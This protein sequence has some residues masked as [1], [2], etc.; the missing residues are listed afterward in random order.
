MSLHLDFLDRLIAFPT[1]S[2]R[3]N[4][5]LIAWAQEILSS[6][7][8]RVELFPDETG[9]K[10]SLLATIG[11][12]AA[13]GLLL[14]GHSD[15]VPVEGQA[16]TT[17]PFEASERDGRVYGR[18][19]ADMKGFLA[20][21][22]EAMVKAAARPPARPL[23]LAIS[24][25]EEIGCVGVR[26]MLRALAGRS[27]R[28]D[29]VLV[30]EPTGMTLATGHK[31]KVAARLRCTGVAAHSALAPTGLNAIH[32]AA[33]FLSDLRAEQAR[34]AE[35]G[36]RDPAHSIPYTTVHAGVIAGGTALNI[37]P[38]QS[39]LDFEIRN[40][41]AEPIDPILDRLFATAARLQAAETERFPEARVAVE[42]VNA[43]PGLGIDP[44]H[45]AL[46]RLK[47]LIGPAAHKVDYGTE[48]GLFHE[49]L[50]VPV[51]VCGPG[52][53]EQGH[54]A[55]EFVSLDQL[56]RCRSVLG[57]LIDALD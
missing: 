56:E 41:A 36:A 9:T 2:D 13:G 42:V 21:A 53:M 19:S 18:G 15:V 55:D 5:A 27:V 26:P 52:F 24:Y 33:D 46:A 4:R 51:A 20:C 11:D 39:T 37:V 43:Y 45:P 48:G 34:L 29:L 44:D 23:G 54:K 12:G 17:D 50:G 10:A 14:S 7:G 16:W 35:A 22:L 28:P 57:G 38:A 8:A 3:P 6:A 32:L 1:V 30:G 25:D 49:A 31:G 40:V 47:A